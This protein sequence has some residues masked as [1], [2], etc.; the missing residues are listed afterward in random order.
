MPIGSISAKLD[1]FIMVTPKG[2]G[3]NTPVFFNRE[4][5]KVVGSEALNVKHSTSYEYMLAAMFNANRFNQC[6]T[7]YVYNGDAERNGSK[8]SSVF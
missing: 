7:R 5:L 6:E 1:M 8:H 3:R 2:M 4:C